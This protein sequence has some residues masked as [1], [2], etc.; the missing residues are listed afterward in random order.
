M[1]SRQ[2]LVASLTGLLL[3]MGAALAA[4]PEE[5]RK[6]FIAL[7]EHRFPGVPND[8]YVN[9]AYALDAS[10]RAQWEEI[11]EFPPYELD[12]SKG[13]ELFNTPFANGKTYASCFRNGGIAIL[14]TF[15]R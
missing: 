9:G 13:E 6:A 2:T 12:I 3:A 5:D 4:T 11:E 7:Y 14:T 8:D 10:A 15:S 1:M